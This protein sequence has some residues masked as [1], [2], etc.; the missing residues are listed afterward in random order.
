[1]QVP[2]AQVVGPVHVNPPHCPYKAEPVPLLAVEVAA[3][4][5]EVVVEDFTLV[6]NVVDVGFAVEDVAVVGEDPPVPQVNGVGPG[7]M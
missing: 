5:D 3:L 7:I 2:L 6:V 4:L 1:M